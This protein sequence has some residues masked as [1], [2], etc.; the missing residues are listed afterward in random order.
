MFALVTL[1]GG[2]DVSKLLVPHLENSK[3]I[4]HKK[5]HSSNGYDYL[6]YGHRKFDHY[7]FLTVREGVLSICPSLNNRTQS[8]EDHSGFLLDTYLISKRT[9][10][11][12]DD[13]W[14][15]NITRYQSCILHDT[16]LGRMWLIG[17]S[18]SA[19]PLWYGIE[20]DH[21]NDE[22]H[23]EKKF[24]ATTDLI[25][26]LRLDF[27]QLTPLGPG[28]VV[29]IDEA[30]MEIIY[31]STRNQNHHSH[32]E[33]KHHIKYSHRIDSLPYIETYAMKLFSAALNSLHQ[34]IGY[35]AS[36]NEAS[37]VVTEVDETSPSSSL[38]QCASN[39]LG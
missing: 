32:K 31:I 30:T 1:L 38:L 17:D 22:S 20:S 7:N 16:V 29:L 3:L 33:T 13:G 10:S 27:K 12:D 2:L 4:I 18:I 8:L 5:S 36:K 28:Q 35:N 14:I 39:A 25:A 37:R 34:S 6:L 11:V 15:S 24:I 9:S 26:A 23:L 21:Y 19:S